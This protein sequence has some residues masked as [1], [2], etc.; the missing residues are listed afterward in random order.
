M[1]R[2]SR[3][4]ILSAALLSGWTLLHYIFLKSGDKAYIDEREEYF[5]PLD[6]DSSLSMYDA[7]EF[8]AFVF[9][10][11]TIFFVYLILF[12]LIGPKN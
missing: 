5:W 11:W 9:V 12:R 10:P 6:E 4:E 2:L 7:I 8:N 3:I 1:K